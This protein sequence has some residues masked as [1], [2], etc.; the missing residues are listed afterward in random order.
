VHAI[1]LPDALVISLFWVFAALCCGFAAFVGGKTG[2]TGA[3]M[4]MTASV[5]SAVAGEFGTWAQ[6]HFPVMAIDLLLLAGFYGLA[7]RSQSYWPIWATGFHLITVVSHVAVLF[8]DSVRQMLYYG[9]GAFWSLPVMLAMV[10]GTV[11]DRTRTP[12]QS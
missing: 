4:I 2:R 10:I 12:I 5:A 8:G 3:A 6:T 7:L 9:F 1:T 11:L